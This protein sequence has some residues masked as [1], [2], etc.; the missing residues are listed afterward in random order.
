MREC[1]MDGP[2]SDGTNEDLSLFFVQRTRFLQELDPGL[3]A[4]EY[5][6]LS[7]AEFQKMRQIQKK[8]IICLWFERDVFCQVNLWFV[9]WIINQ[10]VEQPHVY[11]IEPGSKSPYAFNGLTAADLYEVFEQRIRLNPDQLS[12]LAMLW[13][14]Y[15]A[16]NLDDLKQGAL[17]LSQSFPFIPEAVQAHLDREAKG[18]SLGRPM[19]TLREIMA[20]QGL[21]Q[22]ARQGSNQGSELGSEQGSKPISNNFGPI[23][24]EFCRREAIYG[25]GDLQ[26]LRMVEQLQRWCSKS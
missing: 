16:G 22:G 1:L 5:E 15:V 4:D 18:S 2:V 23:F 14:Y 26:V 7:Q 3:G 8:S 11:V 17:D 25:Y 24:Q 13:E 12:T 6:K 20:E 19:D 9:A 10:Y 21:E